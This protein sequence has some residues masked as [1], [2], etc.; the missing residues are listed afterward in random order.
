MYAG[1]FITGLGAGGAT[2]V[3]VSLL[4]REFPQPVY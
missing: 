1:R 4:T 2:V 3:V